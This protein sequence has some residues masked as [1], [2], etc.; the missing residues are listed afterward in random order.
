MVVVDELA[1][2]GA[3]ET[4]RSCAREPAVDLLAR[5]DS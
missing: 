3:T 4:L 2:P 5:Q 1:P